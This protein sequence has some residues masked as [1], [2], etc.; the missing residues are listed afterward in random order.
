MPI[1]SRFVYWTGLYNL[2]LAPGMATPAVT[3]FLGTNI[4]DPVLGQLIGGFLLFTAITQVFGSRDLK[5]YG[6][7]LGGHPAMDCS[8][9]TQFATRAEAL[10]LRCNHLRF[11]AR[12]E[13]AIRIP[14]MPY[15]SFPIS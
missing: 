1:L 5:T 7:I 6:W 11:R 4:A 9:L 12:F 3:R 8:H 2:I 15:R 10:I 13:A 14:K